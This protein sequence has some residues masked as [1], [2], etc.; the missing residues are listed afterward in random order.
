MAFVQIRTSEAIRTG[1]VSSAQAIYLQETGQQWVVVDLDP[2]VLSFGVVADEVRRLEQN[3]EQAGQ[4]ALPGPQSPH[5]DVWVATSGIERNPGESNTDLWERYL[6]T[7]ATGDENTEP[8]LTRIAKQNANVLDIGFR[9]LPDLSVNVFAISS[10]SIQ[11]KLPGTPSDAL[12]S[13]ISGVLNDV[14]IKGLTD[15]YDVKDPTVTGYSLEVTV[16]YNV[17][18]VNPA[19]F[20]NSI[21][22]DVLSYV[23]SVRSFDIKKPCTGRFLDTGELAG[24]LY[25]NP[26]VRRVSD[27]GFRLSDAGSLESYLAGVDDGF[28]SC[29]ETLNINQDKPVYPQINLTFQSIV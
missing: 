20:Q 23:R 7:R 19:G 10:E 4:E 13:A 17:D 26:D 11:D 16:H 21:A 27:A 1:L 3:F 28:Y 5:L 18:I 29:D 2:Q 14:G 22:D 12:N 24:L 6:E 15:N 9:V 8:G 25:R